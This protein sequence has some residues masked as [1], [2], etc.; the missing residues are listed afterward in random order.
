MGGQGTTPRAGGRPVRTSTSH[1]L[2]IDALQAGTAGGQIGITFCPGKKGP[3]TS[4]YDWD[5]DLEQDLDVVA[6]WKPAAV[7]TLIEDFEFAML[8]VPDLGRKVQAR[9]IEWHHLPIVDVQPPDG[10]FEAGWIASGPRLL[11]FLKEGRRL[12]VHCRGGLGRAGTVSARMLVELGMEPTAAVRTVRQ[13]RPG[14]IETRQQERH[15]LGLSP[16]KSSGG[17]V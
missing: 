2:R 16:G 14:A 6:A 8:G 1:P 12:L 4:G 17:P 7:L 13:A 10:R 15:V 11:Q 5:R 9:G 3:S